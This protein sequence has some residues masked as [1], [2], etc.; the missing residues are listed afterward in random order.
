MREYSAFDILGP[1]MIGPSSSHTAGAARMAKV[2]KMIAGGNIK[3]VKFLL[4]GSFAQTY[5]GHGTD[6][7]L[8]AGMLG[9][10]PWDDRLR[11]SFKIAEEEG[12]EFEF[13]ETDLGEDMHPN[14]V[15]FVITRDEDK[16]VEIVG[17]SIGGGNI[18]ITE[19][20]GEKLEFTGEYPTI[21]TKHVDV[22]GII[23]KV[24]DLL[25]KQDINVAFMKVY[26]TGKGKTACMVIQA[27]S[28]IPRDIIDKIKSIP[29]VMK[30]QVINP[31]KEDE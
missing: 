12:L 23:A 28:E 27:D 10:N 22:P 26:R 13:I 4:H 7:A 1:I 24:S 21:I 19:I 3:K 9:M 14:T 5:R 6:K 11:D 18:I 16:T 25:Y 30:A 8:V 29:K 31:M 20:D 15:K 17:S 2:S